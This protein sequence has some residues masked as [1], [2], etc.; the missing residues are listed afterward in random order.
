M[1]LLRGSF[2]ASLRTG[3]LERETDFL[4]WAG[5]DLLSLLGE[6]DTERETLR[7]LEWTGFLG[8]DPDLEWEGDLGLL[9]LLNPP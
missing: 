1:L 2:L 9:R 5:L 8:G 7:F 6:P 3:L 4:R